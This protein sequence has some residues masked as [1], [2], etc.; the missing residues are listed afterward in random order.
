MSY[1]TRYCY[2]EDVFKT[3]GK[4]ILKTSSRHLGDQKLF[5]GKEPET[6]SKDVFSFKRPK[7]LKRSDTITVT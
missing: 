3:S 2:A 6:G 1:K 7:D 4:Y 5:A